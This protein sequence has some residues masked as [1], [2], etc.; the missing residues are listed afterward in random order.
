MPWKVQTGF[1][2]ALFRLGNQ[3]V[4]HDSNVT[5]EVHSLL[6]RAWQE[7]N[8]SAVLFWWEHTVHFIGGDLRNVWDA[9]ESGVIIGLFFF[10]PCATFELF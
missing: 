1:P 9:P 7:I 4:C 3:V 10:L 8:K 2:E 5:Y 6:H